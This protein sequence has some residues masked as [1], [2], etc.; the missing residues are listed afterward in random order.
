MAM[1]NKESIYGHISYY[2]LTIVCTFLLP[3]YKLSLIN[4][5]INELSLK[6]YS[7]EAFSSPEFE[8]SNRQ[9]V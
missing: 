4:E 2:D 3:T 8:V 7:R 5:Q 9:Y 6:K 1:E